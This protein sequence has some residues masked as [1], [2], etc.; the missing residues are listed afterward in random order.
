MAP[1]GATVVLTFIKAFNDQDLE[2]FASVLHPDVVIHASRGP[3]HG[4][5]EALGWARRVESGELE[6]R[7]ELEHIDAAEDRAVA[8]IRRQWWWRGQ[9]ELAREDEMAWA[10]ELRDGL[11]ASW[12]PFDD[13]AAAPRL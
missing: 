7:I 4:I 5:D 3:R 13:R 11:V 10:F 6:Q 12:R 8:L 1:D 9:D 2:A